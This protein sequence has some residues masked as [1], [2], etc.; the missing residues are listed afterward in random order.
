MVFHT[1]AFGSETTKVYMCT[2]MYGSNKE[3]NS[4]E[5]DVLNLKRRNFKL[6]AYTRR[7]NK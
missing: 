4:L 6:E 1:E 2:N 7:E 5:E 3:L